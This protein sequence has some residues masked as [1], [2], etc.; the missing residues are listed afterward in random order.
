MIANVDDLEPFSDSKSD[1]L[2]DLFSSHLGRALFT[3]SK[4]HSA[5]CRLLVGEEDEFRAE[6]SGARRTTDGHHL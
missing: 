5:N 3:L 4:F 6:E 1:R 2:Q